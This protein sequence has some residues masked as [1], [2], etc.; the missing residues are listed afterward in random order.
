[1]GGLC[2]ACGIMP[3]LV[4]FGV[5]QPAGTK[6]AAWV[7]IAT[8]FVFVCG[9]LA[10]ILDYAL[11][12]GVAADGDLPPGT[13]LIIRGANLVLGLVIVGLMTAISGWI[14]FGAGPREFSTTLSLPFL[15]SRWQSGELPG[16]IAF[17]CSTVLLA[18]MFV[19]CGLSG[20]RRLLRVWRT[21]NAGR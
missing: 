11:A 9:G 20:V 15:P 1:M 16:R 21:P 13:P 12:D 18:L 6:T 4:G 2:I 17:G 10:I 19:A 14:A 5:V 7:L 3:I 8:G